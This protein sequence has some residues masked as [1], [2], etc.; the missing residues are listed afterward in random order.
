MLDAGYAP[1]TLWSVSS[2]L[3]ST[4][5]LRFTLSKALDWTEVEEFLTTKS[6]NWEAKKS[7][8][9]TRDQVEAFLRLPD[10]SNLAYKLIFAFACR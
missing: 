2:M 1:P 9:F 6:K 5:P 4:I 7:K 10:K 3:K 8:V